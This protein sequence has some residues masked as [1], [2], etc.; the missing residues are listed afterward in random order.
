MVSAQDLDTVSFVDQID[1]GGNNWR[2]GNDDEG[3][4]GFENG[5][6]DFDLLTNGT[7]GLSG[8]DVNYVNIFAAGYSQGPDEIES[9]VYDITSAAN[10]NPDRAWLIPAVAGN[11]R[12]GATSPNFAVLIGDDGGYNCLGF[13]E[14]DDSNYEVKVDVFLPNHTATLN[15]S[16]NQFVRLGMGVR[17]QRDAGDPTNEE[18]ALEGAAWNAR[19]SGCY[20]LLYDSSEGKVYPTKILVQPVY[21]DPAWDDI[22]DKSL[23]NAGTT[24]PQVAQFLGTAVTVA[25]GWHTLGIRA[26]GS[27][28]KFIVDDDTLDVTDSTYTV[29]KAGLLYRTYSTV[30]N[31][32]TYDHGGRFDNIR[33]DPAPTPT[34]TPT[35]FV[36][37]AGS[38][39]GLYE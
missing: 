18:L 35:P 29:G 10:L 5:D 6:W 28:L 13:G 11:T 22:R 3:P 20:C 37:G 33:S 24:S 9:P 26:S 1:A 14:W 39:W 31:T 19:P 12:P 36:S 34:P 17:I 8:A 32:V 16:L 27:N 30:V 38:Q 15:N 4:A 23:T 7:A 2:G 21:P 25:E